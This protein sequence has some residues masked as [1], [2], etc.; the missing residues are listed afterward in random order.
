M[1]D[2]M[3]VL[4][5]EY[6]RKPQGGVYE[7]FVCVRIGGSS[8]DGWIN[9]QPYRLTFFKKQFGAIEIREV[10]RGIRKIYG[11]LDALFQ[12]WL[13][14]AEIRVYYEYD[15]KIYQGN[16]MQECFFDGH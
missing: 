5:N 14:P 12:E 16:S 2:F 6:N 15:S 13:T 9:S 3:T 1:K 11:N 8:D 10:G 4:K 7:H